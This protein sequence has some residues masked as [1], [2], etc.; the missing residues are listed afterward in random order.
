MI[1]L[2]SLGHYKIP[3]VASHRAHHVLVDD[4]ER[5]DVGVGHKEVLVINENIKSEVWMQVKEYLINGI[6]GS[7]PS[8]SVQREISS[9]KCVSEVLTPE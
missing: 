3:I 8:V 9:V 7:Y 4:R 1:Q 6:I 2:K 5:E